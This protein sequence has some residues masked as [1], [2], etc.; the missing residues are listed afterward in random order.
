MP[1]FSFFTCLHSIYMPQEI[2]QSN[3]NATDWS[4]PRPPRYAENLAFLRRSLE[5]IKYEVSLG[6]D[7]DAAQVE[8]LETSLA[9]LE[10]VSGNA[11]DPGNG[12]AKDGRK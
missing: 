6:T 7:V 12:T 1:P 10:S 2:S 5:S 3:G 8:R 11:S 4:R 9:A